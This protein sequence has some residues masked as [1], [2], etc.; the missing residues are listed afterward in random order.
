VKILAIVVTG[1]VLLAPI[2]SFGKDAQLCGNNADHVARW[3]SL[4]DQ[5]ITEKQILEAFN[6]DAIPAPYRRQMEKEVRREVKLVFT[7][8]KSI[9]ELAK[10]Y[11]FRCLKEADYVEEKDA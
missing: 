1:L 8:N 4:R 7:G 9:I 11:Y 10:D 3:A 2:P 5:G 6:F